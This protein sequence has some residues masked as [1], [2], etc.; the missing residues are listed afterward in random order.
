M[1]PSKA[2]VHAV[3]VLRR[4]IRLETAHLTL[5]GS[6]YMRN[7]TP[8]IQEAMRLY[9]ES[10]IEPILDCLESG[11]TKGLELWTRNRPGTRATPKDVGGSE[12]KEQR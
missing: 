9:R 12:Q 4:L 7:D 2:Q 3:R 6:P 8:A 5:P 11:D 1:K 10:W